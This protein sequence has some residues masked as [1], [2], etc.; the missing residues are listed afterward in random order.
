MR[1]FAV[2]LLLGSL[3]S[4]T[5]AQSFT[6]AN[7]VGS[8]QNDYVNRVVVDAHDNS[9]LIGEFTGTAIFNK[10]TIASRGP[11]NVFVAKFGPDGHAIWAKNIIAANG[12]TADIFGNAIAVD[13][14][15]NIFIAGG[16][17]ASATTAS[18]TNAYDTL[19]SVGSSD[20][21]LAKLDS[22]G[23]VVWWRQM[24]GVGVGSWGQDLVHGLALDAKSNIYITGTFNSDA[25]F[26]PVSVTS[27][28]TFEIFAAKYDSAGNVKWVR[29]GS[30]AGG[31][32]HMSNAIVADAAG[33]SYITGSFFNTVALGNFTLD[34]VDAEQKAF[35]AKLDNAGNVI[36][37][38][39]LG[40]GGYYGAGNDIALDNENGL[41]LAGFFR[42]SITIG[43]NEYHYNNGLNYAA[44]AVALDTAGHFRWLTKTDGDNQFA[45]ASGLAV[46][47]ARHVY[48][49]GS[50]SREVTFGA[51]PFTANAAHPCGFISRMDSTGKFDFAAPI[52]A[53]GASG[54]KSLAITT[55]GDCIVTG[56]FD[57]S[58]TFGTFALA[59]NGAND[60]FLTRLHAQPSSVRWP[61]DAQ[62][63]GFYPNPASH[64]I[65]LTGSNREMSTLYDLKGVRLR[66]VRSNAT[67]DMSDLP[68]GTY[69]L[70]QH[71]VTSKVI[72]E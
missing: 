61:Q 58:V 51:V 17:L 9:Y 2:I 67:I 16:F 14:G 15:G 22:S 10:I 41:Y 34:A 12:S 62:S 72:K 50:F 40:A 19:T 5:S 32:P 6:F 20:M 4:Q 28:N 56:T 26:G 59:T 1:L 7:H 53:G 39:K 46:D 52:F 70:S 21:Y 23:N 48:F 63:V 8:S 29:A 55:N 68:Q 25:K 36:W 64:T 49:T 44:L 18:A 71:G 43:G 57:T 35:V 33:N 42:A 27:Q 65:T 45:T 37:A 54:G 3:A 38:E 47:N 30:D 31:G 69:L 11:W 66:E 24:G 13:A 60:V